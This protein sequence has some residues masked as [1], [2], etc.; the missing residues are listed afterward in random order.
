MICLAKL[1][2]HRANITANLC[3]TKADRWESS[4][5]LMPPPVTSH[6]DIINSHSVILASFQPQSHFV[7]W[8]ERGSSTPTSRECER[9]KMLS[10]VFIAGFRSCILYVCVCKLLVTPF[11]GKCNVFASDRHEHA[12]RPC[13]CVFV[14]VSQ[15]HTHRQEKTRHVGAWQSLRYQNQSNKKMKNTKRNVNSNRADRR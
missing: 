9:G 1:W 11:D 5:L 8:T 6:G 7:P 10:L 12:H 3:Y 14:C 15:T 4:P 2:F 13:V